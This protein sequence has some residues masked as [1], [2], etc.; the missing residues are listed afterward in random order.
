[1]LLYVGHHLKQFPVTACGNVL[2]RNREWSVDSR[3]IEVPVLQNVLEP[4][5]GRFVAG[6][7]LDGS[8]TVQHEAAPVAADIGDPD[9]AATTP[10]SPHA[11]VSAEI[12][13]E[14]S[15]LPV[16]THDVLLP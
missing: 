10:G 6:Q 11:M 4:V 14:P 12:D 8:H 3:R 5:E 9:V 2:N 7:L 15:A 16:T 13:P 1:V